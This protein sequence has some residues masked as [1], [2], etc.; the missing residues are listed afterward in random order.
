MGMEHG[1]HSS[2]AS[3]VA[4]LLSKFDLQTRSQRGMLLLL[5]SDRNINLTKQSKSYKKNS[6]LLDLNLPM[7]LPNSATEVG[8]SSL[9]ANFKTSPVSS[10][11][12]DA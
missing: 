12:G 7:V 6:L 4:C 1:L 11:R 2:F 5:E 10:A 3:S 8:S 9:F